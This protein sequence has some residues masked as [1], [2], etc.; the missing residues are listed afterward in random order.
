MNKSIDS[1]L[2]TLD[3]LTLAWVRNLHVFHCD[4]KNKVFG[5]DNK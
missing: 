2:E 1:P 4:I 3:S 5:S